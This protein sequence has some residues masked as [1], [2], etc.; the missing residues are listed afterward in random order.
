MIRPKRAALVIDE[1]SG[2]RVRRL[3]LE[4]PYP[5][6]RDIYLT[7]EFDDETEILIEVGCH[8]SFAL[9]HLTRNAQGELE[10]VKRSRRGSIHSLAGIRR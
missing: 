6:S 4:E 7:V 3:C 9:T 8:P 10:P 5:K 2:K 1:A